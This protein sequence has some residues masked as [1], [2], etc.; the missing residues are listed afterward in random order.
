MV[1]RIPLLSRVKNETLRNAA[2]ACFDLADA[3]TARRAEL[4]RSE[5]FTA[6]GKTAELADQLRQEF[7]AKLR[8]AQQ[9]VVAAIQDVQRRTRELSLPA[10]DPANLFLAFQN[11]EIRAMLRAMPLTER[12]EM[13]FKT[14]DSRITEAI[15]TAPCELSGMPADRFELLMNIAREKLHGPAV[16]EI[17]K[18]QAD[19]D[20]AS[21]CIKVATGDMQ[22]ESGIAADQFSKIIGNQ[23]QGAAW[24]RRDGDHILV[25]RPGESTYPLANAQEV[26]T[27]KFYTSLQE[28]EADRPEGT[29]PVP[30][31]ENANDA[32][33]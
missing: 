7:A 12:T 21:M 20:E 9:P 18:L 30:I 11:Q 13:A 33:A 23:N 29:R 32:A 16:A 31:R 4:D 15:L 8:A 25:V 5:K 27:G 3:V 1:R 2:G 17:A 10:P 14:K 6:Q 24:L 28:Y 22:R 26:A 19:V